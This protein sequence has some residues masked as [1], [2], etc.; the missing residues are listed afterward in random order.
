MQHRQTTN[1][2][3]NVNDYLSRKAKEI[4]PYAAGAQPK[5]GGVIKLKIEMDNLR[6]AHQQGGQR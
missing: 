2:R 4:S 5:A 6:K 1:T 3:R